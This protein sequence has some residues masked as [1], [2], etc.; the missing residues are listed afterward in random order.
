[1]R[2]KVLKTFRVAVS[3]IFL[4]VLSFAF[5]DFAET[6]PN[7]F[8]GGFT[9]IQF[10]PSLLEFVNLVSIASIGFVF[11]LLVT[12]LFGRVYCSTVCPMGIMQDVVSRTRTWFSKKKRKKR[13]KYSRPHN[14]LRYSLMAITALGLIFG[15]VIFANLLD[16][17]S[18]FGKIFSQL[19]RPL[20]YGANNILADIL[21]NF[22]VYTFYHVE[23]KQSA[24][25]ALIYP[26][27]ILMLV[28][29]LS[30]RRGRLFCNT[31]CPVG[32]LL[33]L[34]SKASYYKVG[35]NSHTCTQCGKCAAVCKSQCIDVKNKKVDFSRCVGCFNCLNSCEVSGIDYYPGYGKNNKANVKPN[36][37]HVTIDKGR[38]EALTKAVGMVIGSSILSAKAYGEEVI[39]TKKTTI[40][41]DKNYPVTPPGSLGIEHFNDTCTAC[42]L[43]ISACPTNVIQPSVLE[44]G[45]GGFM[46]PRLD[47]HASF[48]NY[49]CIV[50]SEVCPTGA[51]MS[52]TTEAKKTTQVGKVIFE[53]DNCV[54]HTESTSCGACAE[55]CPTKAVRMVPYE[56]TLTIPE[57]DES[58]CV[59]CGAC[60]YACPTRPF[61]AIFV[62]G[63]GEHQVAKLPEVEALEDDEP[64]EEFPF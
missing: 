8:L 56:G 45:I 62:D 53:K 49:D 1:M 36:L 2:Y 58:I 14:R 26:A 21:G 3:L 46:Q 41:N 10:I 12:L 5:V 57:T 50:C 51:I 34:V 29:W 22:D 40:P 9:W 30:F 52:L 44:Y 18:N 31:V 47:Y 15:A 60:E 6:L 39:P 64:L 59:G 11:I 38:R 20:Y 32:T 7:W 55:H 54:V 61:R 25:A 33:G 28:L 42:H 24:W 35:I 4:F 63:N 13:F 16:P 23:T 27:A 17:F 43:C 48:C 19:M 37:S